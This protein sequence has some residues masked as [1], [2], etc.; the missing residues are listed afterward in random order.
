MRRART[1]LTAALALLG[2]MPA[3]G[4]GLK[5]PVAAG[6]LPQDKD[7]RGLWMQVDEA[8][9]Q[10]KTS[11]FLL[12]D[13]ALNAYVR[14]VFCRTVGAEACAGVRIYLLRTADFNAAMMPNGTMM[15]Y[16]GLL[17]RVRDEAQL[18]AVLGHE[19]THYQYRH[20]LR[21]FR[22]AK[23]K[24]NAVAWLSMIPVAGYAAA[25]AVTAVQIGVLGSVYSFSRDM[26]RE[27]DAGSIPLMAKAGYDP[28]EAARVWEQL[29]AEQDATAAAR[30]T[31]S[32]K[33]RTGGLFAS[34]PPTA[35]RV[36]NLRALAAAQPAG[37]RT[38][39][40]GAYR[41][42]LKPWWPQLVDD[43][44]KLNDFGAT[45]YLLGHL[46]EDGWM[47]ELLYARGEL[48]RQRGRPDDLAQAAGFYG[49]AVALADA[50]VEAWRGLGLSALRAGRE[51][52]GRAA[53]KTYLAKRPE[54][55]DRAMIAML[56]GEAG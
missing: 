10:L 54:A 45:E 8:E 17:L 34:H 23:T 25:A 48:Y 6:Y 47:A 55:G 53:L 49:Q 2:A 42:A 5:E 1:A 19:F 26:E 14:G 15:V 35:E 41:A 11:N 13:P 22:D 50:P 27:A 12:R 18:A 36:A 4:Q 3:A 16:S 43:Q 21:N 9:R 51:D 52:E 40:R 7:E 20:S 29:R 32:R 44:V 37:E 30:G 39:G 38:D 33:D 46:A 24:A 28:G 56:A 31:K